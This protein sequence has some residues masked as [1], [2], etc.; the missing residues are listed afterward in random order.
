[1]N[2]LPWRNGN[3]M[4]KGIF[5]QLFHHADDW[6]TSYIDDCIVKCL[7]HI[8]DKCVTYCL[9]CERGPRPKSITPKQSQY[10]KLNI[11]QSENYE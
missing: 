9:P 1:M 2:N 4:F 7:A 5:I 3:Q 10:I 11:V 8:I 6:L